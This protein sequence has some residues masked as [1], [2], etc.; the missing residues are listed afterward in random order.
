MSR[1]Y[2]ISCLECEK[3]LW[4]GQAGGGDKVGHI[5][6]AG[7]YPKKLADFL[8]AHEKHHLIF[9]QDCNDIVEDFEDVGEEDHE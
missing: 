4:I 6:I 7:D 1:T 2:N 8:W 5:Y 3:T 9:S